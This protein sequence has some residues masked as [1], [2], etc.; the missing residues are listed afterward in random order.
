M[1]K[2][3]YLLPI[4]IMFFTS[5]KK[6]NSTSE[7]VT[8]SIIPAPS[9]ISM[10]GGDFIITEKTKIIVP[11]MDPE[12][13]LSADLLAQLI[14]NPTGSAPEITTGTRAKKGSV[15][16]VFDPEVS[17][18][19]GYILAITPKRITINAKTAVGFFYAVQTIRQLLPDMVEKQE[20]IEGLKLSVPACIIKDE[21]RFSYRGMHLDVGR[22]MFPVAT[23]KRYIDMLA[24][25]KMNTFHW[26]LTEDQGWRIEIKK[27]PKLTEIGAYRKETV[28]G[29]AGRPPLKFDGKPYGGFYT[30]D[31]VKD[32]VAYAKSKF[33]TVIPE[34]EMPGHAMGALASYPEL[35]CTGGP[36]EVNTRWG[37]M[38]DVFCAGKDE[39]FTF[40]QDVLTE[41]IDLFPGT[42]IHIGGDECPKKRWEKC[43]LC[44]KRI[45]DEGLKDEH[46]LQSYFI[47]R[48]E[49]FLI[50]KG[51]NLIGWDEILEGGLAPEATVMSWRG[52]RGG[53]AAAKLNHDV[54]M[55]PNTYAYLDYYQCEPAGEPLAIGG[56][57]PLEKVYS[58]NPMPEELTP[59][60]Q[61]HIL[62]VQGNVWTEYIPTSEHLE[63]MAFPR[64][65]AIAETGWTQDNKKDFEDFL[66]RL[67]ILKKRY[68]A[69]GINYFRGEYRDTRAAKK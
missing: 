8:A 52:T 45:K 1:K 54:I 59:D 10:L 22:H 26:H 67:E 41:V 9:S 17:N 61:K 14:K 36:F 27:Y 57:L 30:Q 50:S 63:Y 53:I 15:V 37:V 35:S 3:F 4:L 12:I 66:A 18:D 32:V 68:D 60:E 56:Y 48:I 19:E 23:I 21:P 55:T 6:A 29:H 7:E 20:V 51:R 69:M 34:I 39:V 58:Y 47:Q 62:G 64:A 13:M 46:E 44:Q 28:L 2:I 38:D 43:P 16:M 5:C 40:L 33:I 42:Y 24:L 25:H 65:I 49:K 11:S 31:E